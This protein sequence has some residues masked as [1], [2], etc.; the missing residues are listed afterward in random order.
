MG[1]VECMLERLEREGNGDRKEGVAL[2]ALAKIPVSGHKYLLN[3]QLTVVFVISCLIFV[4]S[5]FQLCCHFSLF[6]SSY[7]FLK[8]QRT[9]THTHTALLLLTH[10]SAKAII[11]PHRITRNWYT[12]HWWVGCYIWYGEEGTRQG[13]SPPRS[14]LAGSLYQM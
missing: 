14:I 6:P 8:T 4:L 13:R 2:C 5:F 10:Y 7:L 9:R 1:M 3:S 12:D 11:V